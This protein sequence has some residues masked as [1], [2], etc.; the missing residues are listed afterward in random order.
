MEQKKGRDWYPSLNSALNTS[1]L[2]ADQR[3][4]VKETDFNNLKSNSSKI[5]M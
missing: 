4:R 3:W 2:L 5:Q 1:A